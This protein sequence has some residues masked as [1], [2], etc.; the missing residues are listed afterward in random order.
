[1]PH[2]NGM[3]TFGAVI[4]TGGKGLLDGWDALG[5]VTWSPDSK[6]KG[7]DEQLQRAVDELLNQIDSN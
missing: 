7:N 6:A 3:P 4:S 5:N 2:L 1:M